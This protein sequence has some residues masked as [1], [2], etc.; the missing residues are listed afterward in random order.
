MVL[1]RRSL[2]KQI[3]ASYATTT[4]TASNSMGTLAIYGESGCTARS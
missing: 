2:P 4:T 1:L 3:V